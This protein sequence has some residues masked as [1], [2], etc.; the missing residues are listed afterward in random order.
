MLIVVKLS[1]FVYVIQTGFRWQRD[2]PGVYN[3]NRCCLLLFMAL[4]TNSS[5]IFRHS[6]CYFVSVNVS[7]NILFSFDRNG[8]GDLVKRDVTQ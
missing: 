1:R 4:Y 5:I 2:V 6:E 3:F 7:L 8:Y